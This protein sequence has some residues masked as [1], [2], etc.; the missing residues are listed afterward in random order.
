MDNRMPKIMLN[1]RSDVQ[2]WIE[3]PLKRLSDEAKTGLS[4]PNSWQL[5]MMMMMMMITPE[6]LWKFT[7][8]GMVTK[9]ISTSKITLCTSSCKRNIVSTCQPHLVTSTVSFFSCWI[10]LLWCP[11]QGSV[12]RSHSCQLNNTQ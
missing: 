3:R 12:Q 10:G 4:R 2:R 7:G 8:H 11:P 9:H 6:E 5:M 1:Y